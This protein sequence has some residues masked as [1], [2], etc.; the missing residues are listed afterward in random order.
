MNNTKLTTLSNNIIIETYYKSKKAI[1][2]NIYFNNSFLEKGTPNLIITYNA[3][4][5]VENII[6]A[7]YNNKYG[8]VCREI[9]YEQGKKV[10]DIYV[11]YDYFINCYPIT[12]Y[13]VDNN[14]NLN[15]KVK[16]RNINKLK[17]LYVIALEKKIEPKI[18][19][20]EELLIPEIML[21]NI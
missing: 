13:E 8:E 2:D 17:T 9:T 19:E 12:A 1:V 18:A 6:F 11:L 10:D 16:T 20:I 3:K 14:L 5:I 15:K 21:D 7:F 4:G